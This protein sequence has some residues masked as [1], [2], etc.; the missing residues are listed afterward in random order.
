MLEINYKTHKKKSV[1]VLAHK[2]TKRYRQL[3]LAVVITGLI[4]WWIQGDA[5]EV[6]TWINRKSQQGAMQEFLSL[7]VSSSEKKTTT[8]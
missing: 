4:D 8:S 2:A 7:K 6:H 3:Q 5:L 1:P